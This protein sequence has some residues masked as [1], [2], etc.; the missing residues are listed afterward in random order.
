MMAARGE[1]FVP[2]DLDRLEEQAPQ[3]HESHQAI[4]EAIRDQDPEKAAA[5]MVEHIEMV[6]SLVDRALAEARISGP[7]G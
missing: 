6:E 2:V 7:L 4:I 3:V 1:L 5:R